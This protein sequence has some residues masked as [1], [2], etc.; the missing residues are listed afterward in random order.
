MY[1]ESQYALRSLNA[2]AYGY[3]NKTGEASTYLQAIR[4][5][6]M[7]KKYVSPEV[8]DLLLEHLNQEQ[9]SAPHDA[10]SARELQVL[11]KIAIGHSLSQIAQELVLS[12]KT[13]S[14]YRS[15]VLEKLHL[16]N[17]VGLTTYAIQRHLI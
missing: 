1:P 8:S 15:R 13:V 7:G 14:V 6:A 2:G 9:H 5:V 10:L 17:N 12:P 3:L 11:L 4:T 16:R